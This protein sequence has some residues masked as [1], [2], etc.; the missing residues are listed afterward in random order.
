[1]ITGDLTAIVA[2]TALVGIPGLA[3]V[4]KGS[5]LFSNSGR[6]VKLSVNILAECRVLSAV[7]TAPPHDGVR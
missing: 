1:M 2:T 4:C 7:G 6:G 5:W 3:D